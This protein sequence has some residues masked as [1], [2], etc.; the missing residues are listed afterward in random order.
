MVDIFGTVSEEALFDMTA[1]ECCQTFSHM[2]LTGRQ[3]FMT[4]ERGGTLDAQGTSLADS[5]NVSFKVCG[6]L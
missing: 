2:E 1:R 4:L 6:A 3:L 5:Y